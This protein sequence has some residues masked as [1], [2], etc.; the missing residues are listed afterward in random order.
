MIVAV[1]NCVTCKIVGDNYPYLKVAGCVFYMLVI[2]LLLYIIIQMLYN[3]FKGR[4][5]L[6]GL[7]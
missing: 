6:D 1:Q 4:D 2:I 3:R 5:E 7:F